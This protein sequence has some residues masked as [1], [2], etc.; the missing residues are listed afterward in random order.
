M[1]IGRTIANIRTCDYLDKYY[2]MFTNPAVDMFPP[3][4]NAVPVVVMEDTLETARTAVRGYFQLEMPFDDLLLLMLDSTEVVVI[5]RVTRHKDQYR[6]VHYMQA[7]DNEHWLP[8][9]QV[10]ETC[11]P[12]QQ[13]HYFGSA[14]LLSEDLVNI[15]VEPL[16]KK[17]AESIY[18][19]A[20]ALHIL[21]HCHN[22]EVTEAPPPS[23][24]RRRI[25][26]KKAR[27]KKKPLPFYE[28]QVLRVEHK[29]QR[30]RNTPDP[31]R[32]K[33]KSPRRHH[34]RGYVRTDNIWVSPCMVGRA[35]LG[36][37]DSQY[38]YL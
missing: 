11:W 8:H 33:R 9:P 28:Y 38:E 16:H 29:P 25:D 18:S 15:G 20:R 19:T 32:E 34:R 36:L 22:V 4:E 27:K 10:I 31:D 13:V 30:P 26:A 1:N 37:V 12:E 14:D 3:I 6:M 7:G 5:I 23:A 21:T 35:D 2:R 17:P 24:Q